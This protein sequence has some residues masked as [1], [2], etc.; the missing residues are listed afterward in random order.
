MTWTKISCADREELMQ[1]PGL[2]VGASFTDMDGEYGDPQMRTEWVAR[3]GEEP[4]L[5]EVRWPSRVV[6]ERDP[7]P[8]EHWRWEA[9]P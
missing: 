9:K 4:V 2:V 7:R 8:C 1:R 3:D 5:R 6:G